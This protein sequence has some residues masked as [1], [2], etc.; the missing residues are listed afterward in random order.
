MGLY[1]HTFDPFF[2][3]RFGFWLGRVSCDAADA[4]FFGG[5][6]V[7]QDGLDYGA[8]LFAS[9]AENDEYLFS[10]HLPIFLGSLSFELLVGGRIDLYGPWVRGGGVGLQQPPDSRG[11]HLLR[12]ERPLVESQVVLA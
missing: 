5:F 8:P 7:V 6:G 12:R 3:K 11:R 1:S 9:G 4:E 10:G 2:N